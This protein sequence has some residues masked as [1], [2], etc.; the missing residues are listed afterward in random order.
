[1][2]FHKDVFIYEGDCNTVLS[3]SVFPRVRYEDYRRGLCVL[4]PYGLHLDWKVIEAAGHLKTI[5]MFLNFPVADMNRNALW[6]NPDSVPPEQA[7]RMTTFWG[8]ESWRKAA[9]AKTTN[10][11][12]EEHIEKEP[13]RVV[14]EAF[15]ERL[16]KVAGFEKVPEPMPMRNR[17]NAIVYYL[18]FASQK[19][20]AGNIVLDIFRKYRERGGR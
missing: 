15:R 14:A 6:R 16:R 7:A 19:G 3:E 8:D 17:N 12:G 20:T 18:F 1:L 10:L 13:N 9:Y 11:F 2:G 5:D 4:D